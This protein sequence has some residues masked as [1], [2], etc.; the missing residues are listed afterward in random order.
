[1][2]VHVTACVYA[3]APTCNHTVQLEPMPSGRVEDFCFRLF[4]SVLLIIFDF[5]ICLSGACTDGICFGSLKG[6]ES[7]RNKIFA[8]NTL[9]ISGEGRFSAKPTCRHDLVRASIPR[10]PSLP[11]TDSSGTD[12]SRQNGKRR[13][14]SERNTEKNHFVANVKSPVRYTVLRPFCGS[15]RKP[16]HTADSVPQC[17]VTVHTAACIVIS[18][19]TLY[20]N[21]S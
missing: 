8:E 14:L 21:D 5:F 20:F 16:P 19:K 17:I 9:R 6:S 15:N 4:F 1:M 7:A 13:R 10:I 12:P 3:I 2:F 11:K 18:C